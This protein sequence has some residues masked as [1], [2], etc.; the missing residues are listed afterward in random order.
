[1]AVGYRR[2]E[3]PATPDLIDRLE[4]RLGQRLPTSYRD[5]LAA[6]DG[7]RLLDNNEVVTDVF[8][9]GEVPDWCSLWKV[10]VTY[11]HRLPSWLLPV[12]RDAF[13]NLFA[14]S[15]RGQDQ[16]SVWFWDHEEEQPDEDEPAWEEN[17]EPKADDWL[18]FLDELSPL[19]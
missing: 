1:M 18:T 7:G 6:Q 17:I 14:V 11:D 5:Y 3:P 4:Q 15:L 16:G 12:A 13:G 10:L 19:D 8:G 9:L 2:R